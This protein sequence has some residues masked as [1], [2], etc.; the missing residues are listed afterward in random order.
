M[1]GERGGNGGGGGG[2]GRNAWIAKERQAGTDKY[3][4]WGEI[5]T[6]R[7]VRFGQREVRFGQTEG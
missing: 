4:E 7:E 1:R 5:W 2:A 3:R 6:E